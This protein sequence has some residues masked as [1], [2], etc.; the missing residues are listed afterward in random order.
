[1]IPAYG[2]KALILMAAALSTFSVGAQ[3]APT[4][5][6]A[7][8]LRLDQVLQTLKDEL[9]LIEQ[10][11]QTVEDELVYPPHS[12]VAVYLGMR[13]S[14]LLLKTVSIKIDEGPAQD[15]RFTDNEA[16]ALITSRGLKRLL[17]ANV[18]P[19]R[20]RIRVDFSGQFADAEPGA[21]PV[22]GS[23]QAIFDKKLIP[24]ELELTLERRSRYS[25][26]EMT[27]REWR[28]RNS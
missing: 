21:A 5:P 24:A 8:A 26:P 25:K 22:T 27:L 19:G 10:N 23:Y 1:M 3:T 28:P 13:I 17:L 18:A 14:G 2:R 4:R 12:R 6:D 16:K 9:L 7:E 15:I 20:H 11:A